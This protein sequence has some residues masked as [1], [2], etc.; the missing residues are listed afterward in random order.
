MRA[1]D[2]AAPLGPGAFRG[3]ERPRPE[4]VSHRAPRALGPGATGTAAAKELGMSSRT[5]RRRVAELLDTLDAGS[6]FQAGMSAGELGL[7]G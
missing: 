2:R 3:V 5:S 6:R 1:V 4:A 7:S